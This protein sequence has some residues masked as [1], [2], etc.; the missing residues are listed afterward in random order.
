MSTSSSTVDQLDEEVRK[1]VLARLSVLSPDTY[2]SIGSDGSFSRDDLMEH[3]R[4][5]DEIGKKIEAIEIEWVRSWKDR[6]MAV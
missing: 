4:E 2:L 6:S 5:G 3:V 1:L